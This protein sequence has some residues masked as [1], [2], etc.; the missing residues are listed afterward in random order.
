MK[1]RRPCRVCG[2]TANLVRDSSRETGFKEICREHH[3][4]QMRAARAK[5]PERHILSIMIQRCHNERHPKFHLYGGRGIAVDPAWRAK[6]GFALFFQHIGPRPTPKHSV[7]RIKNDRGYEPGNVRWATQAEQMANTRVNRHVVINGSR[8][9]IAQAEREAG[10]HMIAKR[11]G[12]GWSDEDAVKIPVRPRRRFIAFGGVTLDL[13]DWS[14]RLGGSPC[15]VGGRLH[16]GWTEEE[17]VSTPAGQCRTR[18]RGA[19]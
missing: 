8:K 6:G 13:R 7:D 2:T 1:E 18:Q 11:L 14:K 17:A 9:C 19:A 16:A 3:K 15:L 4:E 10:H 12:Q 5:R